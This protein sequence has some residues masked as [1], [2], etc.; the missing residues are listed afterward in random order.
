[1]MTVIKKFILLR[2]QNDIIKILLLFVLV[3]IVS[4]GMALYKGVC[5]YHISGKSTCYVLSYGGDI[6]QRTL[7]KVRNI[8]GVDMVSGDIS[9]T[10][11]FTYKGVD[12]SL[13]YDILSEE[14]IEK[15]YGIIN[16]SS[17]PV[18]YM[19]DAAYSLFRQNSG[20]GVRIDD[21]DMQIIYKNEDGEE[22]TGRLV[23]TDKADDEM[24]DSAYVFC[25][26]TGT[27]LSEG[28]SRLR[29]HCTGYDLTDNTTK[30][31]TM[32][33]MMP[34]NENDILKTEYEV[35][36]LLND[37][38]YIAFILLLSIIAQITLFQI[39]KKYVDN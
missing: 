15:V 36:V 24:G 31:F 4:F 33:G 11:S 39:F 17:M 28:V 8:S 9:E 6:P 34:E 26:A 16:N 10:L 27:E 13:Q 21:R 19:N 18:F 5:L 2:R 30:E 38:H 22:M 23:V 12:M 35:K 20:E 29:V 7:D 37:I 1:M 3:G 32:C 25:A 14:Y